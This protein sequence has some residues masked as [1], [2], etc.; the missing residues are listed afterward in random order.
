MAAGSLLRSGE[1]LQIVDRE[2][3]TQNQVLALAGGE[4]GAVMH[5]PR[6]LVFTLGKFSEL[7]LGA[8]GRKSPLSGYR[9]RSAL[10]RRSFDSNHAREVLG[11]KPHIGVREGIQR[12]SQV[13]MDHGAEASQVNVG[14]TPDPWPLAP[15]AQQP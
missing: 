5:V 7:L 8:L 13:A 12:V 6:V 11:W 10:A 4:D 3:L 9:L 2:T 15:G 1:I 14:L